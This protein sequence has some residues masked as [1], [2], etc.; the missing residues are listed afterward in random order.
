MNL[1]DC[2]NVIFLLLM[3][4]IEWHKLL[5]CLIWQ[6]FLN[7][8]LGHLLPQAICI[9]FRDHCIYPLASLYPASYVGSSTFSLYQVTFT[10]GKTLKGPMSAM[11]LQLKKEGSFFHWKFPGSKTILKALLWSN[12]GFGL[13]VGNKLFRFSNI[14]PQPCKNQ[15]S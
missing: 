6:F 14:M 5:R 13:G 1:S 9:S 15:R 8:M 4:Y 10:I 7:T 2:T 3:C 12:L 11:S